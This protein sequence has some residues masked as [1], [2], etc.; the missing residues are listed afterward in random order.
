VTG[1]RKQESG[2][3]G[4][5]VRKE[6]STNVVKYWILENHSIFGKIN[7]GLWL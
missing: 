1:C 6:K 4:I 2:S 3:R 5:E 7:E